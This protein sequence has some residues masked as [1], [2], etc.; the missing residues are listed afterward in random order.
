MGGNGILDTYYVSKHPPQEMQQVANL[1]A[2]VQVLVAEP[3]GYTPNTYG[4]YSTTVHL[5]YTDTRAGTPGR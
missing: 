3:N 1:N 4:E 2:G 5:D